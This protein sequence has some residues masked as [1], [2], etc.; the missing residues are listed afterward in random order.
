[1][2]S[3][4]MQEAITY[5]ELTL[6]FGDITARVMNLDIREMPNRH[7]ELYAEAETEA[8]SKEVILHE[9]NGTVSLNYRK[10]GNPIPVFQGL[11]TRLE[12]KA[13]GD[14]YHV[15]LHAKTF[16]FLMDLQK[17]TFAYQD[18]GMSFHQLIH[19]LISAFPDGQAL[20]RVSDQPVGQVEFQYQESSWEFIKRLASQKNCFVYADSAMPSL[21]LFVGLPGRKEDVAWD[22]FPYTSQRDMILPEIKDTPMGIVS[23]RIQTYDIV[24]LGTEVLFHGR[25]LAAAGIR[26]YLKNGLLINEYELCSADGQNRREYYNPLLCGVS[27]Y[28]TVVDVKRN[29]V[30]VQLETDALPSYQTPYYYPF[31]T[32]A[33]SPDGSGW[34]CMPK[35]GDPVRIFFP[36]SNEREGYAIANVQGESSPSAG[37]PIGN[38]ELKDITTPD[39]KTVQ[40]ISNG[41]LLSVNDKA[42][43]VTLTNDGKAK[44]ESRQGISIHAAE[45]IRMETQGE[46]ELSAEEEIQ[47]NCVGG[48][49]IS[50]KGNTIT[51]NAAVIENN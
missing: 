44:V 3:N 33:A 30:C 8:E 48:G 20:V 26:R 49:S 13:L 10:K 41:I 50:I 38:P 9:G 29:K 18:P 1:M 22:A 24:P 15:V 12:V 28:G 6:A 34:Y 45:E 14:T 11:I 27:V 2:E 42:G 31:S 4:S 46:T 47:I 23:Y 25:A 39:G 36:T 19:Q 7:G 17:N 16:S 40:F 32:V 51:V 5:T 37:S 21:C 43:T 35:A